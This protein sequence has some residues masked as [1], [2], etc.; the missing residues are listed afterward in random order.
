MQQSFIEFGRVGLVV[1]S[2]SCT[3]LQNE[4]TEGKWGFSS[5]NGV[6]VV[7]QWKLGKPPVLLNILSW[8][9]VQRCESTGRFRGIFLNYVP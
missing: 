4:Q 7:S 1:R 6:V 3:S 5:A 9:L 2:N 8:S